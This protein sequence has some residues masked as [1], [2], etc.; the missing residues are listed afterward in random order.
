MFGVVFVMAAVL[1]W[2]GREWFKF[3]D[4]RQYFIQ[5]ESRQIFGSITNVDG[6]TIQIR[7]VYILDADPSKSDYSNQRDISVIVDSNTEFVRTVSSGP[8]TT[9]EETT[10]ADYSTKTETGLLSDLKKGMSITVKTADNVLMLKNLNVTA[11]R[12]EYSIVE[13]TE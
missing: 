1:V 9:G 10:L 5:Q 6:N 4:I 7:G 13:D 8:A 2:F 12:I 11:A 3:P